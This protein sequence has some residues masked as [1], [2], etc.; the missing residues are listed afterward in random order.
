MKDHRD[1][2]GNIQMILST[3]SA[4]SLLA[5][6][7]LYTP[8]VAA[9]ASI[10]RELGSVWAINVVVMQC[11]VAWLVSFLIFFIGSLF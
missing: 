6:C 7:L 3:L 10:K 2:I 11:A 4:V 8:C 9:V 5:F 1:L